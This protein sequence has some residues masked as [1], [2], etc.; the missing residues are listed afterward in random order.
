MIELDGVCTCDG[1]QLKELLLLLVGFPKICGEL[2][3]GLL[4]AALRMSS[5]DLVS[6][7]IGPLSS[8]LTV[9]DES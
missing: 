9:A 5:N 7:S 8:A 3:G 2:L 6:V 4:D 1:M